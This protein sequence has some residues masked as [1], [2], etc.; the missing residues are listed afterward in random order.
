MKLVSTAALAASLVALSACGGG[1]EENVVA[2]DA[3]AEDLYN[4]GAGDLALD[5]GLDSGLDNSLGNGLGDP[6]LE[7][8]ELGNSADVDGSAETDASGNSQ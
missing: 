1:A 8:N 6:A 4:V 5:N 2:N 3:A 7:G